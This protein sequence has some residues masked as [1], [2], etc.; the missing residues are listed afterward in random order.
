MTA[1]HLVGTVV[2]AAARLAQP[3][4]LA[5]NRR[6]AVRQ[7]LHPPAFALVFDCDTDEDLLVVDEVDRRL[8]A[9]GIHASYAVPGELLRA[10]ADVYRPLADRG[11][12]FLN[13]GSARHCRFDAATR[14]YESWFFY[15]QLPWQTVERDV[16]EGHAA[17]LDVLGR[18]P[19]GFRT[20]HFGTFQARGDLRRLYRLLQD[21]GYR[22]SSSTM[23][24]R[25]LLTGPAPVVAD[26]LR[27]LAVSGRPTDPLRV[28]DSWSYRFAPDRR[29]H[30]GD[31]E[32]DLGTLIEDLHAGRRP[33]VNV[34]ADPSQ[35]ADWPGFFDTVA[36]A[37]P[38]SV[39]VLAALAS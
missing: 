5:R 7:G 1:R 2:S 4:L 29:L 38:A 3:A 13:H 32:R 22:Y 30:E 12:E 37:A 16:R 35:V 36:R 31:F 11:R 14:R 10:G 34:Y 19:L 27:E 26:G 24:R 21:L 33:V 25:G 20:P 8:A 6:Q 39:P 23:P 15:D 17:H 28:V 18:V 9:V